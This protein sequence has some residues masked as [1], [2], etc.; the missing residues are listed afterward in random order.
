MNPGPDSDSEAVLRDAAR[1]RRAGTANRVG[2]LL[3]IAI[4]LPLGGIGA[5]LALYLQSGS[6][7]VSTRLIALGAVGGLAAGYAIARKVAD[8]MMKR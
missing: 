3:T 2:L 5:G 7:R 4:G 1:I 8:R 6:S